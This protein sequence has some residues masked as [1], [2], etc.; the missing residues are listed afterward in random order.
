MVRMPTFLTKGNE[1]SF[2]SGFMDWIQSAS[3]HNKK[4]RVM[5]TG[6]RFQT[7]ATLSS[8]RLFPRLK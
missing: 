2:V 5:V 8:F 3:R 4:E 7:K 6:E 1:L